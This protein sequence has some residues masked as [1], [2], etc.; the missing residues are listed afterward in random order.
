M[1]QES[2][3]QPELDRSKIL[4]LLG[5]LSISLG[6]Y[7][8]NFENFLEVFEPQKPRAD[9]ELSDIQKHFKFLQNTKEPQQKALHQLRSK[10]FSHLYGMLVKLQS[11]E[12][13]RK[14]YLILCYK[15]FD[16]DKPKQMRLK[17]GLLYQ[18][19]YIDR[20]IELVQRLI[21]VNMIELQT[22]QLTSKINEL[23]KL[24]L[25]RESNRN[26]PLKIEEVGFARLENCAKEFNFQLKAL[27]WEQQFKSLHNL[28]MKFSSLDCAYLENYIKE[29]NFELKGLRWERE[30]KTIRNR[31]IKYSVMGFT[32]LEDIANKYCFHLKGWSWQKQH[33]SVRNL[34]IK[35]KIMEFAYPEG[36]AKKYSFEL[37]GFK[38]DLELIASLTDQPEIEEESSIEEI[39][40]LRDEESCKN[41]VYV[42]NWE[43]RQ[44]ILGAYAQLMICESE[45]Y[46]RADSKSLSEA[47]W[48]TLAESDRH[49][50]YSSVQTVDQEVQT[51]ASDETV[52]SVDDQLIAPEGQMIVC[53]PQ[54]E[55]FS[56]T[57]KK[58]EHQRHLI[59]APRAIVQLFRCN[60][61]YRC[62]PCDPN[63]PN[64]FEQLAQFTE[65]TG[66]AGKECPLDAAEIRARVKL[67][68][69]QIMY[70][71]LWSP[72]LCIRE[73]AKIQ[74]HQLLTHAEQREYEMLRWHH[75]DRGVCT[76][77]STEDRQR[78]I[79]HGMLGCECLQLMPSAFKSR[80]LL[81]SP[82]H[83]RSLSESFVLLS[84]GHLG[85]YYRSLQQQQLRLCL[86]GEC[87]KI[88]AHCLREELLTL[89]RFHQAQQLQPES[90]FR[91]YLH[92]RSQ[93]LRFQWLLQVCQG[94]TRKIPTLTGLHRQL[95]QG[96]AEYEELLQ[97]WLLKVTQPLLARI[98]HWL[99]EGHLPKDFFIAAREEADPL[100]Y[101]PSHFEL[102]V[103]RLPPFL[104]RNSAQLLLS[105]GRSQHYARTYLNIDLQNSIQPERL[106]QQLTEAYVDFVRELIEL[107]E[108]ALEQPIDCYD[109]HQLNN[110]MDQLLG[111]HNQ[112][113]FVDQ[114]K[115]EGKLCWSCFLLGWRLSTHWAALLG[116]RLEQYSSCFVGLW[117]LHHADYVLSERIRRQ[118]SH[119]LERIGFTHSEDALLVGETFDRFID[120]LSKFMSTLRNYFLHDVLD[121]AFESLF[122]ACKITKSL[123]EFLDLHNEYLNGIE[124]G[125]LQTKM[126][127]KSRQCLSDLFNI[128]FQLDTVQQK[129]LA[130]GQLIN[131]S[132][133]GVPLQEFHWSCLN[134]CDAINHLHEQFQLRLVNFL[135]ALYS[136]GG[137]QFVALAKKLDHNRYYAKKS[138]QLE[139]VNTFRFQRKLLHRQ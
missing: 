52:A 119:F 42:V 64:F 33:K 103:E 130:L 1:A 85:F 106:Q 86:L 88:L 12:K 81:R 131:K 79:L 80:L 89:Y 122:I 68:M 83:Q 4:L 47:S 19:A 107:L 49:M 134:T 66:L 121:S 96:N 101:W 18:E 95:G 126:G 57:R 128:I 84:L 14:I 117:Q 27:R 123:D 35:I 102:I 124:F 39:D 108:P 30:Q 46:S 111:R 55:K 118:Q 114:S 41:I 53:Y 109:V 43:M 50:E 15:L 20:L 116:H 93:Q 133:E 75:R 98:S 63:A 65:I 129:F 136:T 125:V 25:Q 32:H 104:D 40:M 127:L 113:L 16:A 2:L 120:K 62:C 54:V 74:L 92:T 59:A 91:L 70:E 23:S 13:I 17:E 60:P 72:E 132:N 44:L 82:H 139:Q 99:L 56:H 138:K 112:Q 87:G 5:K 34:P 48:D 61:A 100:L 37:K 76:D 26:L 36:Y 10:L 8:P 78:D 71:P 45:D 7:Q 77:L 97:Q 22:S 69:R 24:H 90:L 11:N 3:K 137:P 135:L 110:M 29:F 58:F 67:T 6:C 94:L 73:I 105:V 115:G 31:P 9:I 28:P 38:W 21:H 51:E